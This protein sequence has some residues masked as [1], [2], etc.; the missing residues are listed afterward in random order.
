[1]NP[2][3]FTSREQVD[4]LRKSFEK[5]GVD[6]NQ[7][8]QEL[9]ENKYEWRAKSSCRS[10]WGT[11]NIK[12]EEQLP[13]TPITIASTSTPEFENVKPKKGLVDKLCSC[14]KVKKRK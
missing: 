8:V 14:V 10:C 1:M 9:S 13:E 2:N 7:A 12:V 4:N 3:I 11:G 5:L 6:G